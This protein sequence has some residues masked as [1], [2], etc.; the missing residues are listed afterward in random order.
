MIVAKIK[1]HVFVLWRASLVTL[2]ICS[3]PHY[4]HRPR[5]FGKIAGIL[6]VQHIASAIQF[7][8]HIY[9]NAT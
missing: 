1:H 3:H 8:I 4:I 6:L 9:W 5:T 7:E 2:T